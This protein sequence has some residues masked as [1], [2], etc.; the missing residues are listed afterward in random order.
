SSV[1]KAEA[2]TIRIGPTSVCTTAL[3]VESKALVETE[4]ETNATIVEVKSP[5]YKKEAKLHRGSALKQVLAAFIANL[6]TINTGL[7]FGF[8][9]V[10]IPQLEEPTSFIKVDEDQNPS[11]SS[12]STPFGCLLGGYLMDVIGRKRTLIITEIPLIVGWFLISFSTCVEMIYVGRLLVGLGSGMVGAPARVYTGEVTQPHLRGML[13]A[14]ASV[15]V[16]LGVLIEYALGSLVTWTVLAGISAAIP[17][18]ALIFIMLMPETPN[19][20]LTHGYPAEAKAA[21]QKFRL[22][23]KYEVSGQRS[24][25]VS[26]P[27]S[28]SLSAENIELKEKHVT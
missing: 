10:A 22:N 12:L 27:L 25:L 13:S 17:I 7:V 28:L 5:G 26:P 8:S 14:L 19:W 6:G 24:T 11:L 9:A 16:S 4:N 2:A 18:I 23:T 20:L 1:L 3:D 15:G 21:L